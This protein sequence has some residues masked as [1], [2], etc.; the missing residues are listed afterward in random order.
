[1]PGQ[2][3]QACSRLHVCQVILGVVSLG[4]QLEQH[5]EMEIMRPHLESQKFWGWDSGVVL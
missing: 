4:Q 5:L 3:S 2:H 1:M